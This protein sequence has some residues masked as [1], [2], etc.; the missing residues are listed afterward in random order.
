MKREQHNFQIRTGYGAW[1][2]YK[3]MSRT[4]TWEYAVQLAKR[5]AKFYKS[6][7]RLTCTRNDH[8]FAN[9]HYFAPHSY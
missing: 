6:E 3:A 2:D 8:R 9:G 5:A 7:V 4:C 1:D